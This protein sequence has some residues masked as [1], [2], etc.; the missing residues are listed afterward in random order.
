MRSPPNNF[1]IFWKTHLNMVTN[2]IM[3]LRGYSRIC[4]ILT[5]PIHTLSIRVSLSKVSNTSWTISWSFTNKRIK[6]WLSYFF[7]NKK[8]RGK[9]RHPSSIIIKSPQNIRKRLKLKTIHGRVKIIINMWDH[10]Y[11]WKHI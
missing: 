7:I 1:Y 6:I 4:L 9:V 2:C 10:E 11:L 5:Q 3:I 8:K